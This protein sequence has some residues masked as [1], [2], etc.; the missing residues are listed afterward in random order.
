MKPLMTLILATLPTLG[1]TSP[2]LAMTE[3]SPV[4]QPQTRFEIVEQMH[5]QG[6]ATILGVEQHE[7]LIRV[8]T[9][10]QAG[11]LTVVLN[12]GSGQILQSY[13]TTATALSPVEASPVIEL[14][15]QRTVPNLNLTVEQN[16]ADGTQRFLEAETLVPSGLRYGDPRAAYVDLTLARF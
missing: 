10:D 12:P 6:Y 7:G 13:R 14:S 3:I 9:V 2:G 15:S 8:D 5:E 11:P 16:A 1:L 4:E